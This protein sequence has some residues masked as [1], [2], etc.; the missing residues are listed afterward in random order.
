[1]DDPDVDFN[2]NFFYD[3]PNRLLEWLPGEEPLV[4]ALRLIK[5]DDFRPG[6]AMFLVMND[7]AGKAVA[8]LKKVE[9][10]QNE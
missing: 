6:Y 3:T 9:G 1:L 5:V 4:Q 7:D 8:Y 2:R 10:E